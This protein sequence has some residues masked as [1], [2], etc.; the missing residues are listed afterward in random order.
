MNEPCRLIVMSASLLLSTASHAVESNTS[1]PPIDPDTAY[2]Q[3]AWQGLSSSFSMPF[4]ELYAKPY[5]SEWLNALHGLNLSVAYGYPLTKS[6]PSTSSTLGS[7]TQ[8]A[9]ATNSTLQLGLKY[10]PLSYWF[11][12]INKTV[13]LQSNLQ[14][15][16]NPDFSYSFGYND[17]HPWALSL[18]YSNN[19]GNDLG[20]E[21]PDFG[22][23]QLTLSTAFSLP[24]SI[25]RWFVTGYGDAVGCNT[26]STLSP[27]SGKLT[28]TFGCKYSL[29]NGL[30]VNFGL[31]YYPDASSQ[32]AWNPDFSYSFG[33]FDWRPG[34]VS[35]SY[36]NPSGNRFKR[37]ET[38][39]GTGGFKNGSLSLSWSKS[40]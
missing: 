3:S 18:V 33:Y 27:S 14:N 25:E 35:F 16:W 15:P 11:L 32:E 17:W 20:G 7:A 12:S 6:T 28:A 2:W 34:S 21:K 30:Y 13:Y 36:G 9:A 40:W 19:L 4:E 22:D 5:D 26:G 31:F 37:S 38:A 23:G 39:K 24:P 8:G 29:P 10:T 1:P